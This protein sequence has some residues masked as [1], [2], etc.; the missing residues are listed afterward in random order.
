MFTWEN[1]SGAVIWRTCGF[2]M[3]TVFQRTKL[4]CAKAL[5]LEEHGRGIKIA[6]AVAIFLSWKLLIKKLRRKVQYNLK[7]PESGYRDPMKAGAW[8]SFVYNVSFITLPRVF[9]SVST[10]QEAELHLTLQ[11]LEYLPH[12]FKD[13]Y[14]KSAAMNKQQDT[15]YNWVT[16]MGWEKKR[17]VWKV[18]MISAEETSKEKISF[19]IPYWN[20]D[21]TVSNILLGIIKT[22]FCLKSI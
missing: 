12:F 13:R 6:A 14:R 20:Q 8:M 22:C 15:S 19:L 9:F 7:D 3:G 5:W 4:A 11:M 16:E 18:D 21:T 2:Y 10:A 1:K 17:E